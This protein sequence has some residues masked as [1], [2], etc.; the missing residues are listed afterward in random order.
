M[1][2]A[3]KKVGSYVSCFYYSTGKSKRES[4]VMQ[5]CTKGK[6]IQIL[7]N[8][9]FAGENFKDRNIKVKARQCK[10]SGRGKQQFA[11]G[12]NAAT[13]LDYSELI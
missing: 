10:W 3:D 12:K 8:S 11:F 9:F 4:S 2:T 13:M 1:A 5:N 7:I 6:H